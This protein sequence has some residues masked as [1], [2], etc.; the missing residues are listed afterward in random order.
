M[1]QIAEH[2][3]NM[4]RL[5]TLAQAQENRAFLLALARTGNARLAA[6]ELGAHR[7][8]FTKRRA[9]HPAFAADWDAALA[10]AQA[11]LAAAL[12]A[13]QPAAEMIRRTNGRLQLRAHWPGR[14]TPEARQAF[15]S[16]LSATANIR[17]SAKAAGFTHAAFYQ[18]RAR[19]PGFAREWR[20]ALAQG[21]ERL[22]LALLEGAQPESHRDDAWRRNDPPPIPPMTVNQALQLLHLHQKEARLLAE[23]AHL[24]RRRGEHPD[25]W[26]HRLRVMHDLARDRQREAFRLA[27]AERRAAGHAPWPDSAMANGPSASSPAT[28]R[29]IAPLPDL[30]QVTGWSGADPAATPHDPD[31]ALFGG[32]RLADLWRGRS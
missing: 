25:A 30:S 11:N 31:T 12:P 5:F 3:G 1:S 16:A 9:A 23:P 10:L 22:E 19:D 15:L 29:E 8:K 7:A 4:A 18:A 32:W 27:E 28:E 21:Y 14:L 13:R 6:R 26:S 17:L 24:K 20:L 2:N